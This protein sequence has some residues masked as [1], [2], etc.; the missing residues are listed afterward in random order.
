MSV[1]IKGLRHQI[2]NYRLKNKDLN[3][4]K[5][6][7]QFVVKSETK[8]IVSSKINYFRFSN[9]LGEFKNIIELDISAAYWNTALKL[10][11]ITEKLHAEGLEREKSVRLIALGSAASVKTVYDYDPEQN[12]LKFIEKKQDNS[13]RSA[14][15][16]ISRHVGTLMM[17]FYAMFPSAV[18]FFWVDALFLDQQY[19]GAAI[20]FFKS[21]GYDLKQKPVKRVHVFINDFG[22]HEYRVYNDEKDPDKYKTFTKPRSKKEQQREVE[23]AFSEIAANL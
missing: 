7:K 23:A 12:D 5:R 14:F 17:D 18:L 3:F 9:K 1:E 4:V 8:Q 19:Q 20:E 2:S 10:G 15:F 22:N 13:G 6:V 11:Y 16:D 21:K